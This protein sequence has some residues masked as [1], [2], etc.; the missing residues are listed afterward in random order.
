MKAFQLSHDQIASVTAALFHEVLA[1][2]F[3]RQVGMT[4]RAGWTAAASL[5]EGGLDLAPDEQAACLA[6]AGA[7]FGAPD[8]FAGCAPATFGA[9]VEAIDART[10]AS[11]NVFRFTAAGG[12]G[13]DFDHAADRIFG[14]AAAL[15]N[16]LYG[17]RRIVSLVAP[18]SLIGFSL[19]VLAPNL[20][21]LPVIDARGVSPEDLKA[22]LTF[23]DAVI[24]T[25]SLWRYLLAQEVKAP[26]NAMAVTFGEA[27]SPELSAAIRKSGFG[28]QR[29]IYGSTETGLVGWR[30]TPSDPFA[31]F[32][33]WR[34]DGERLERT[35]PSGA[36]AAIEPMDFLSWEGERRFRLAGRR[37]GAVQIGG[38][39]AFPD[40]I[41]ARIAEHPEV[42]ECGVSLSRHP[43]G[44]DR[45][46]A[47][48]TLVGGEATES[49][50]RSI[51]AWCRARLRPHERPRVYRFRATPKK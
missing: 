31:L 22:A 17:R 51:D 12:L 1:T 48:I 10:R 27:L 29:E 49:V 42:A 32:E 25:P 5:G 11:L 50:V 43:E 28:A 14:E 21:G 26:D 30:D 16:L 19:A 6:R 24:A 41:A 13:R 45:L 9:V 4:A 40:D 37:D 36:T 23:G 15:A 44:V 33:F 47:E 3:A 38:V 7:F 20:L 2:E 18:H 8:L 39:N 35:A 34:R 46:V